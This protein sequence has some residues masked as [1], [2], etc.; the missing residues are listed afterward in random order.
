MPA[1]AN[2]SGW[3]N[4][5]TIPGKEPPP[6]E[7][8][9]RIRYTMVGPDY[10][11]VIG[12]RLLRGHGFDDRDQPNSQ[13]VAVIT[14]TMA[15]SLWPGENPLGKTIIMGRSK[16]VER[17]I[18]GIAEDLRIASLYEKPEM[19]VY[20]PFSQQQTGF[21]LLL[22]EVE[23]D[24]ELV[25]SAVRKQVA[26]IDPSLPVLGSSSMQAHMDRILEDE[27]MYTSVGLWLSGLALLLGGVGLYGVVAL[28]M[29]RRTK[30]VGIRLALGARRGSVLVQVIGTGLRLSL[31][32]IVM[33]I[34][35]S[36]AV[37][38][39]LESRLYGVDSYDM[40]TFAVVAGLLIVVAVL[41]SLVPAWRAS[42]V[43]PIIALRCE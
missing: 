16:P 14:E 8:F 42:Y 23:G 28:V 36:V 4:D 22:A 18:V 13:P 41:A 15:K 21:A 7:D 32:G 40:L 33:G 27:R 24:P 39:Y 38:R 29:T 25:F 19:Y 31:C 26:E 30:E 2:E 34:A 35:G 5:F 43:D 1:W 9:F 37:S 11:D 17:E 6:G 10:F 20:V 3:A 12:T